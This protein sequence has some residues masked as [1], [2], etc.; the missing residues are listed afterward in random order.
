MPPIRKTKVSDN[1]TNLIRC[2]YLKSYRQTYSRWKVAMEEFL[3]I[4]ITIVRNKENIAD[5]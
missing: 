5:F 1:C 4:V 3:Q 2:T